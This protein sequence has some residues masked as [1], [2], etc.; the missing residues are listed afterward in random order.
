VPIDHASAFVH[1]P[2]NASGGLRAQAFTGV[3]GSRVLEAT[4]RVEGSNATFETTVPLTMRGGL[5]IDIF[6]P[7][8]VLSEPGPLKRAAWF[9]GSNPIVLLPPWAFLAM[10]VL[11]WFKGRD[12]NPGLSVAPM[13][14]PPAKMS[15]AEVGALLDDKIHPRDITC[16]IVDLAVR[17]YVKIEEVV[18]KGLVFSHKDYVFHLLKPREQWRDLALHEQVMLEHIFDGATE[19][20]LSSLK[21]R[22]YTAIPVIRQDI[23]AALKGKG[24]YLVDPDLANAYMFLG[25]ALVAAPFV[26]AAFLHYPVFSSVGLVAVS[27]LIAAVI[28]WLF[29]R[30]MTA[31]TM[32]GS[33][34]ISLC[35]R[36][37]K[38]SRRAAKLRCG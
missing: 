23:M 28:V 11:W 6:I 13:Y 15:P 18:V 33:G 7:K 17:G 9:L 20:R 29:G 34:A 2:E 38:P 25:A 31:K 4:A 16:T 8:G 22:F 19:T 35:Q 32:T 36:S 3:Y 30:Q 37:R 5:T 26:I 12:P 10:F 21:N 24:M 27:V 1:F 14:E